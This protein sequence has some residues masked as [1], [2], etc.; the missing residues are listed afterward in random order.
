MNL[1]DLTS[2]SDI[3]IIDLGSCKRGTY[4]LDIR[5]LL[6]SPIASY[7][8]PLFSYWCTLW[9]VTFL[10]GL[11]HIVRNCFDESEILVIIVYNASL[12]GFY[13]VWSNSSHLSRRP[14]AL[15]FTIGCVRKASDSANAVRHYSQQSVLWKDEHTECVA[16][17]PFPPAQSVWGSLLGHCEG[18][19]LRLFWVGW[20]IWPNVE[21]WIAR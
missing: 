17:I 1:E 12:I 8:F 9:I 5:T 20:F 4:I 14:G 7:N 19:F 16:W 6:R 3:I 13:P 18:C 10:K 11:C 2:Y 15:D 21:I